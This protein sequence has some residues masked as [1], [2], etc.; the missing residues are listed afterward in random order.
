M[1]LVFQQ[2][3]YFN[4]VAEAY[5]DSAWIWQAFTQ[6]SQPHLWNILWTSHFNEY[7]SPTTYTWSRVEMRAAQGLVIRM[8]IGWGDIREPFVGAMSYLS[9]QKHLTKVV[10]SIPGTHVV[11]EN[12]LLHIFFCLLYMCYSNTQTHT[13]TCMC[14]HSCMHTWIN[15]LKRTLCVCVAKYWSQRLMHSIHLLHPWN[16]EQT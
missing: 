13:Y 12:W 5:T 6:L 7:F 1:S 9:R 8:F 15:I 11:G 14:T 16:S 2:S 4:Q 10:S 3:Q